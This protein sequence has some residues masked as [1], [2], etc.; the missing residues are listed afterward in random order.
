MQSTLMPVS[1]EL[2]NRIV[3]LLSDEMLKALDEWRWENRVSSRGEAVR[4]MV[5]DKLESGSAP[6]KRKATEPRARK[7]RP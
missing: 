2:S 1:A 4:M 6:P 7:G 5:A 3:V